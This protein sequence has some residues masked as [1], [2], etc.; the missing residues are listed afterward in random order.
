MMVITL[1]ADEHELRN[2]ITLDDVFQRR[3]YTAA[4]DVARYLI[5]SGARPMRATDVLPAIAAILGVG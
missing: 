5:P 4:R 3:A 2:L 1:A